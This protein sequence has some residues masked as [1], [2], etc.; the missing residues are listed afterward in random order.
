MMSDQNASFQNQ[1]P[2]KQPNPTIQNLLS[3]PLAVLGLSGLLGGMIGAILSEFQMSHIPFD[4]FDPEWT[5]YRFFSDSKFTATGVW[6]ALAML[7]IG[8]A[9]SV[10]QGLTERNPEKSTSAALLAIPAS[11]VGGFLAGVIAQAVFENLS[12]P[13]TAL[14]I[15]RSIGWAIAGG[16]GGAAVGAGFRSLMRVRNCA[17]GG[18]AGGFA[19]GLMF[20]TIAKTVGSDVVS[21]FIALTLIGALM[22]LAIAVIDKATVSATIEQTMREG[23]PI[24]FSIFDQTTLLGCAG[25]VGV[26]IRGDAGISEHHLRLT[27]QGKSLGFQCVG[28]A[29]PVTV[30]GQQTTNGVLNNGDVFVVGTTQLRYIAGK[31]SGSPQIG[32]GQGQPQQWQGD[33]NQSWQSAPQPQQPVGRQSVP[34][35]PVAPRQPSA[36]PQQSP[37]QPAA[38]PIIQIKKPE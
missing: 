3:N 16:L 15:P 31:S 4:V 37:Q 6:F 26:T 8:A 34:M 2:V 14:E 13:T 35:Q 32:Q 7:G 19:G 25:N 5:P 22:G 9:M 30:N 33:P 1:P 17:L 23:A 11:L 36:T 38:R 20:D 21:R 24:R 12:S 28:N 27:R 29:A 18:L 10:S